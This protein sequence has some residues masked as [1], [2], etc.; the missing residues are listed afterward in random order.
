MVARLLANQIGILTYD[1]NVDIYF[2]SMFYKSHN[3][4]QSVCNRSIYNK[5]KV[6]FIVCYCFIDEIYPF[7]VLIITKY[8]RLSK[9]RKK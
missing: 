5:V 4:S 8:R 3:S 2:N 9:T 7:P 6:L 1:N